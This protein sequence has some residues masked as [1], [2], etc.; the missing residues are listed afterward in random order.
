M[1]FGSDLEMNIFVP[2]STQAYIELAEIADVK[3]QIISPGTSN[4]IIGAVQD[5]VLGS[6]NL[7]NPNMRIN[8]KDAMNIVSYTSIDAFEDIKKN[9]DYKGS[10]LFSLIIPQ[11]I[12]TNSVKQG[13]ITKGPIGKDHLKADK[14][15][16]LIHL[17][18]DEYGVEETKSFLD[19]ECGHFPT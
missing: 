17:I 13:K 5:G 2:Q 15:N 10:D 18:W 6:Y 16:S 19:K 14:A 8:W 7:T 11:K 9:D 4:P 1:V 12:N 3:R